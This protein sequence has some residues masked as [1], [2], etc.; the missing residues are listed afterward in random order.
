MSS[1]KLL[2]VWLRSY[3]EQR[4]PRTSSVRWIGD[5]AL[6]SYELEDAFAA[7][8]EIGDGRTGQRCSIAAT[9]NLGEPWSCEVFY[10]PKMNPID[11]LGQPGK[12]ELGPGFRQPSKVRPNCV[13]F[14]L[15]DDSITLNWI[16]LQW[17]VGTIEV[18]HLEKDI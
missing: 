2:L 15:R 5:V 7:K 12:R 3:R 8:L 6:T 1:K 4:L 13:R 9:L 17:E 16:S 14:C 10:Q 11:V 18:K